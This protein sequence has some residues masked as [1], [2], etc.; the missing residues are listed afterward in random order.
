MKGRERRGRHS[1]TGGVVAFIRERK[2]ALPIFYLLFSRPIPVLSHLSLPLSANSDFLPGLCQLPAT[3]GG[4][5]NTRLTLEVEHVLVSFLLHN[6]SHFAVMTE[7]SELLLKL[8]CS[9]AIAGRLFAIQE[10]TSVAAAASISSC[11]WADVLNSMLCYNQSSTCKQ[12]IHSCVWDKFRQ[13]AHL[14]ERKSEKKKQQPAVHRNP[15]AC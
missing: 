1:N 3:D 12:I 5:G 13:M 9:V 14:S 6:R 15:Y 10:F 4:D 8:K 11:L 2:S 7:T